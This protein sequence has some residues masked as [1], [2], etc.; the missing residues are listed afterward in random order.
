MASLLWYRDFTRSLLFL[1][2]SDV[3]KA[4]LGT[5]TV[6]LVSGF[7]SES[8]SLLLVHFL[9]IFRDY[10]RAL[11]DH[12]YFSWS[13]LGFEGLRLVKRCLLR[14]RLVHGC[15]LVIVI[16]NS[17]DL[18]DN[19][20]IYRFVHCFVSLSNFARLVVSSVSFIWFGVNCILSLILNTMKLLGVPYRSRSFVLPLIISFTILSGIFWVG[21]VQCKL[22]F[23][24]REI[25]N[26][27]SVV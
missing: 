10:Q 13:L 15:V 8:D 1:I 27:E 7:S 17:V 19:I 18:T 16:M 26:F 6:C 5:L 24:S 20:G 12:V 14:I 23:L 11:V 4:F 22:I 21:T 9:Q 2:L 3:L 25:P